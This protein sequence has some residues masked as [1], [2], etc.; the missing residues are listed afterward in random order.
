MNPLY[1]LQAE[2][3]AQFEKARYDGREFT[4]FYM[5]EPDQA[6]GWL[7]DDQMEPPWQLAAHHASQTTEVIIGGK[8]S[9]KTSGIGASGLTWSTTVPNFKFLCVAPSANQSYQMFSWIRDNVRG[10]LWEER[11][12]DPN[13]RMVEKPYPKIY[14]AYKL[15]NGK[16]IKSIMEF[17]S[18]ADDAE[19]ILN[20]EGDMLVLDQAEAVDDLEEALA[21]LGTRVRG[22]IKGRSRLGRVIMLANADDNTELW[23]QFDLAADY[24]DQYLAIG[25]STYGNKNL[26]EQQI[27]DF[28]LRLGNDAE[29]IR[30]HLGAQRPMGQG[31]EFKR[32]L[33]EMA[34]EPALDDVMAVAKAAGN[35]EYEW[36]RLRKA[37]VVLWKRPPEEGHDYVLAGDPGTGAAPAR[38][39][40]CVIVLD[41]TDYPQQRARLAAFWW[42][43]GGGKY[44]AFLTRFTD[45]LLE[46]HVHL[47]A[48][49]ATG[50]Q[51]VL[52]ET[53]FAR[54]SQVLPID[55]SGIKKKMHMIT[56]KL[57][58][59]KER[60]GLPREIKG[61]YT[62][63]LHYKIPDEKLAQDIVSTF[64]V[65]AGLMWATGLDEEV[66]APAEAVVTEEVF[67]DRYS[68]AEG[69]DDRTER[70]AVPR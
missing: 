55:L 23:G 14:I 63:F 58:M 24:P 27:H 25:A 41:M 9:G 2:D 31:F 32:E 6:V 7:F 18:A 13:R 70:L 69:I 57:L 28:E 54:F 5:R 60:L 19:R 3:V 62:Q 66:T 52:S 30:L 36:A 59:Q 53:S 15:P 43:N 50:G 61:L 35:T 51:K 10:T 39:A 26:T 48:Y 29:K 1:T 33:L 40:P 34:I 49:D 65:W 46:Y 56:L 16:I 37:D 47:A 68:R 21:N 45:W 4:G 12:L 17:M 67:V 64:F 11:F 22:K 44:E 20:Y 8:G 38:N 42:G